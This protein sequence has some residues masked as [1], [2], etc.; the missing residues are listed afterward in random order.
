MSGTIVFREGTDWTASSG[1]FN[2]VIG[3][4]AGSVKDQDTRD[5]LRLTSPCR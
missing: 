4:L 3:C 2:W 5:E 1:V